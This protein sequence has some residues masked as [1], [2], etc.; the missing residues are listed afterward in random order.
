VST[1]RTPFGTYV[2]NTPDF[3]VDS[4]CVAA[5]AY[6]NPT[7]HSDDVTIDLFNNADQGQYL[8]VYDFTV[9]NDAQGMWAA[10]LV[11]GHGANFVTNGFS[12][13][14]NRGAP[15]GVVYADLTA[16]ALATDNVIPPAPTGSYIFGGTDSES[17]S[18]HKTHGPVA[19]I[20]PGDSFRVRSYISSFFQDHGI[21]VTFYYVYLPDQG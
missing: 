13:I 14:S 2:R 17:F 18:Q 11:T 7:L 12:V 19:V 10:G 8:Y 21:A 15:Y 5:C 16:A 6:Q 3:Y 9:F 4:A 1:W 20:A